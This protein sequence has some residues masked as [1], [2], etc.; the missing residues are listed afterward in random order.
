MKVAA[1]QAP[2]LP[3]G[4][5][6]AIGLLQQRVRQG[7]AEGVGILCTPEAILGGLADYSDE[8]AAVAIPAHRIGD[9]LA[10]LAS[11]T[12][13]S[14]VG[15]TELASSGALHNCA[16][17]YHRGAVIGVYRKM[18]PAINRSVYSPGWETPV[19]TVGRL[20]FGIIICNDSNFPA[21]S[22]RMA[23]L[24]A[25]VIF[26][27]SN[28]GLPPG[29]GGSELVSLARKTDVRIA[30]EHHLWIVRADVAGRS[31]HLVS[32]GSTGVVDPNGE[33]R[34]VAQELCEGLLTAA[35]A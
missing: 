34:H 12:V 21:L 9:A 2:L 33:V 16:A 22:A 25:A 18:H 14:I 6:N 24:G 7:E 10:P 8:P 11:D 27:P 32:H 13:T 3:V 19:F 26:V 29:K 35:V 15:F 1:Y 5:M 4:S 23:A 20:T 17:V 31:G 28:N 30:I